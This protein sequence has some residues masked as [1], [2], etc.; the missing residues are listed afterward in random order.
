MK[1][2]FKEIE[3][4]KLNEIA[5]AYRYGDFDYKIEE[6]FLGIISHRLNWKGKNSIGVKLL[7]LENAD[8]EMTFRPDYSFIYTDDRS[9]ITCVDICT[10]KRAV[11]CANEM[12]GALKTLRPELPVQY[13]DFAQEVDEF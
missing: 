12:N 5:K 8:D 13:C 10:L 9:N 1:E 2:L 4:S 3:I 7:Y 11:D 6:T